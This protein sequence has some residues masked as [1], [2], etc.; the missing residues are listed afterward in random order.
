MYSGYPGLPD[1]TVKE[2][3]IDDNLAGAKDACKNGSFHHNENG[4]QSDEN[5]VLK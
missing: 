2:Y 3:E 4:I 5:C 1:S